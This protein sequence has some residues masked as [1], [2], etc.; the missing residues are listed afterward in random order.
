MSNIEILK[1][2]TDALLLLSLCWLCVRFWRG[3]GLSSSTR[4]AEL[5]ASLR[6][7]MHEAESAGRALNEQLLGRQKN[8][9]RLLS[10]IDAVEHRI[11]RSTTSAESQRQVLDTQLKQA[12]TLSQRLAQQLDRLPTVQVQPIQL[13]QELA[14]EP[15]PAD[16]RTNR[17][18][19][20]VSPAQ[21]SVEIADPW[22]ESPPAAAPEPPSFEVAAQRTSRS[23]TL[24]GVPVRRSPAQPLAARVEKQTLP[25]T[26][27]ALDATMQH[28]FEAADE[29]MRAARTV[30]S[31]ALAVSDSSASI[32]AS[33]DTIIDSTR[34][35][36]TNEAAGRDP[37]L[38]VLGGIKRQV[39]LV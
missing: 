17:I 14:N 25:E 16:R 12:H 37:R 19:V 9:E 34:M 21:G 39:Q 32:S 15:L 11:S 35:M 20:S 3:P 28:I 6:A 22:R 26:G 23:G 5:D 29:A 27:D 13:S 1:L 31:Q 10:D 33:P 7:L 4:L 8:M 2:T 38:G 36:A 24:P 18:E 30:E